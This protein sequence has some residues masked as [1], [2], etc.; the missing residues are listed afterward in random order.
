M[1]LETY[2]FHSVFCDKNSRSALI[3]RV[4]HHNTI[5]YDPKKEMPSQERFTKKSDADLEDDV[6]NY[7]H[8]N[9]AK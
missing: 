4:V 7:K 8:G 6:H 5:H 2:Y 1:K 3:G 9:S